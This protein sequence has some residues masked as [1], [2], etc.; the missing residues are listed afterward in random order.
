MVGV[1][2]GPQLNEKTER[3]FMDCSIEEE[4]GRVRG[5]IGSQKKRQEKVEKI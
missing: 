1:G 4:Q 3:L 2:Q 5:I